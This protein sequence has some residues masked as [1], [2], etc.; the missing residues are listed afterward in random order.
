MQSIM[1]NLSRNNRLLHVFLI[2]LLF[3]LILPGITFSQQHSFVYMEDGKFMLDGAEYFPLAVS[4][5]L[6]I[7]KD[8]NG[9]FFISPAGGYCK[10][11]KCG[12]NSAFYC[13]TNAQEWKS[14][15]RKHVNKI[16]EMGFNSI[17]L[18]GL[19]ARHNP[20]A[21][22]ANYLASN[23]YRIQYDPDN[24]SCF[25]KHKGYKIKRKTYSRQIDLIE[26]FI[27][28][29]KE[30]NEEFPE[31]S[32]KVLITTGNGGLQNFSWQ[33]TKYLSVLGE[34]FKDNPIIFAYELNFEAF[35][36]G[37]PKFEKDNKYEIANNMAQ[38][39]YTLKNVAPSQLITYGAQP[40]DVFNWDAESF[41]I[42]F[43]NFHHY[44]SLKVPYDKEEEDRYHCL[45]KWMSEVYSKPWIIGETGLAGN[46][47]AHKKNI[48]IATE[49]EQKEFA[50]F[51]LSYARWY[52]G[53]GYMWWQ[54][55]EVPWKKVTD[56]TAQSNYYGLV[57]M[58][59]NQERHK[60]AAEAFLEFDPFSECTSCAEPD[61]EKYYNPYG[62]QFLNIK[63]RITTPD[64]KPVKNVYIIGKAKKEDYYTFSNEAGEFEIFSKTND[65][66]YKLI[67]SYPGMSVIQL[68]NWN[69]ANLDSEL[70]LQIDF[71]DKSLL[72]E[73]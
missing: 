56:S 30:H 20:K 21:T 37:N 17:R 62:Y 28:I 33:Y 43:I 69:E 58:K 39:Y 5:E 71:L 60:A 40:F 23:K 72:P 35:Y 6:K 16:S 22:G 11:G 59:D 54:Y 1:K 50:D 55:K 34:R 32:L 73:Q 7:I 18:V 47:V 27:A 9:D 49:T 57:R 63:G 46:N 52:G 44:S 13:G 64:G 14:E 51:T 25:K 10:W 29:I 66:I 12:K 53:I 70:D 26:Q 48:K 3:V 45:L 42:D 41:P 38:W 15:I 4:Y 67:A 24:L 8:I 65:K 2:L 61:P 68:G 31:K 19:L 36:L